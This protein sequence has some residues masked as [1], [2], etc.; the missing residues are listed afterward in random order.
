LQLDTKISEKGNNWRIPAK[1]NYEKKVNVSNRRNN[2]QGSYPKHGCKRRRDISIAQ[3][4]KE[5]KK[6]KKQGT[7]KQEE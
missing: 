7:M 1:S 5:E 3:K 4:E 6:T 2:S